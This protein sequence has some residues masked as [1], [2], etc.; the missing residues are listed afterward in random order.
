M[1]F[2]RGTGRRARCSASSLQLVD[3]ER[4]AMAA[5]ADSGSSRTGFD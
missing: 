3:V 1:R 5:I 4:L 2:V